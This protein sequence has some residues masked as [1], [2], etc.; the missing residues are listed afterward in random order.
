MLEFAQAVGGTEYRGDLQQRFELAQ[1]PFEVAAG[2]VESLRRGRN[3]KLER[4]GMPG[5]PVR[6]VR[7]DHGTAGRIPI[8]AQEKNKK[9]IAD[10]DVIAVFEDAVSHRDAIDES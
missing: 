10:F 9:R 7:L 8:L 4:G 2:T 1:S 6:L 5:N 3:I